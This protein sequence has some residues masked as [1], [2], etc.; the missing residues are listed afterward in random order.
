MDAGFE[1]FMCG[2]C[3]HLV[4]PSNYKDAPPAVQCAACDHLFCEFCV[5]S[6][7]MWMCPRKECKCKDKPVPI[8]YKVKEILETIKVFFITGTPRFLYL[9]LT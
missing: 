9:T 7:M 4:T 1:F 2:L 3:N 8:H 6:Q 5:N